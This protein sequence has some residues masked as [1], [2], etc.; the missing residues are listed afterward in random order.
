MK[1]KKAYLT[2]DV[3]FVTEGRLFVS[4]ASV[5]QS[6]WDLNS[7]ATMFC[8]YG[9]E[10]KTNKFPGKNS[11]KSLEESEI[12]DERS[13]RNEVRR[14]HDDSKSMSSKDTEVQGQLELLKF[15]KTSSQNHGCENYSSGYL[16]PR[17]GPRLE[18]SLDNNS[19]GN[20]I[21]HVN[22]AEKSDI[23]ESSGT[24]LSVPAEYVNDSPRQ[25]ETKKT[26]ES[27]GYPQIHGKFKNQRSK[28]RKSSLQNITI[29]PPL[30][31]EKYDKLSQTR[32]SISPISKVTRRQ[33]ISDFRERKGFEVPSIVLSK[34][35][36][37]DNDRNI[38]KLPRI[39]AANTNSKY[40]QPVS[41]SSPEPNTLAP[42]VTFFEPYKA[43]RPPEHSRLEDKSDISVDFIRLPELRTRNSKDK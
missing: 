35:E 17:E 9:L 42:P 39:E 16:S 4:V 37:E 18:S 19:D 6:S 7:N 12:C 21:K 31:E 8:N 26:T 40:L 3:I 22:N 32:S 15:K 27:Q 38:L 14:S 28:E 43:R 36:D 23:V 10:R 11:R 20:V 30:A 24:F 5:L 1:K 29:L 41:L 13:Q 33:T 34:P 25:R 2:S